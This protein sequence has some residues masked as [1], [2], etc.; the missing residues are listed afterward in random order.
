MYLRH[1]LD[2][3][4]WH[5]T[6]V[7]RGKV[8]NFDQLCSNVSAFYFILH[9]VTKEET[10]FASLNFIKLMVLE[11]EDYINP[12]PPLRKALNDLDRNP[13]HAICNGVTKLQ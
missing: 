12:N 4:D 11:Q 3:T 5:L 8:C 7:F 13:N 9:Y 6:N 10:L 1:S 2:L